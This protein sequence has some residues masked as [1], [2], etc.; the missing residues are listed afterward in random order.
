M[1]EIFPQDYALLWT[2]AIALALF[3]AAD[4][5][6]EAL[7]VASLFGVSVGGILVVPAVAYADYFGRGSIGAIR[8]VTEPFVSLGQ[9][10]GAVFSGLVYDLTGS[11]HHAFVVLAVTAVATIVVLSMIKPPSRVSLVHPDAT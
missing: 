9:A 4:S 8:G 6:G 3:P 1:S 7:L 10:I 5:V 2:V 11:Y